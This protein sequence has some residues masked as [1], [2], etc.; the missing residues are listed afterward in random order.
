MHKTNVFFANGQCVRG[1]T[2]KGKEFYRLDSN[3][4]EDATG[5]TVKVPSLWI[6]GQYILYQYIDSIEKGFYMS[7]DRINCLAP[8]FT[9]TDQPVMKALIGCQDRKIRIVAETQCVGQLATNGAVT[10]MVTDENNRSIIY[11]TDNG[12]VAMIQVNGNQANNFW[13]I[14][15]EKGYVNEMIMHDING[16][17]ENELIVARN[18]GS[19]EIYS[20][21]N[22]TQPVMLLKKSM[23]ESITCVGAGKLIVPE[24][25]DILVSTYSGRVVAFSNYG[26]SNDSNTSSALTA[27]N[28]IAGIGKDDKKKV[29]GISKTQRITNLQKEIEALEDK[30]AK[31][32]SQY[33]KLSSEIVAVHCQF[34]TKSSFILDSKEAYYRLNVESDVH[35][36]MI[37]VRSE[38]SLDLIDVSGDNNVVVSDI[39]P[40]EKKDSSTKFVTTLRFTDNCKR[41]EVL[42]RTYE[43]KYGLVEAYVLPRLNPKISKV[44]QFNVKPLSLH[45]RVDEGRANSLFSNRP[46]SKLLIS[47]TF[48]LSELHSWIGLCVE[49]IPEK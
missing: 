43:G 20:F 22:P 24:Y 39:K 45:E 9:E 40:D 1:V 4:S 44:H 36:D 35:L 49:G 16:D 34:D 15:T 23:D 26:Y 28:G 10:A 14:D 3:I 2:K 13:T 33:S 46:L 29:V 5:M 7:P 37:L 27:F 47:G 6:S 21:I 42:L 38:I 11:G 18:D 12:Q 8:Y 32:K 25:D 48:S 17:G 41:I 30:L 19:L 31:S